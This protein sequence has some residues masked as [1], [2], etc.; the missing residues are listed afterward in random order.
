MIVRP[1]IEQASIYQRMAADPRA[2]RLASANAGSGKTKVLVERVS[3]LLLDGADPDK[4]L[5]LTYTKAAASEMQTRLFDTLGGWSVMDEDKLNAALDKLLGETQVRDQD[6]LGKARQL[7][8]KALETPDGLKVQTI[9]AFCERILSRFPLEAG[10]LPGFEPMDDANGSALRSEIEEQIYKEAR[11]LPE[12]PL[13]K[14][15][16]RLAGLKADQSLE[17][18]F[19]WIA[20]NGEAIGTW[21]ENGGTDG[22]AVFLGLEIGQSVDFYYAN[23]WN[24]IV[25]EKIKPA[26]QSLISSSNGNDS[27][28]G[29]AIL[30]ALT[31]DDV[32]AAF[33]NYSAIFLTQAGTLRKSVVTLQAPPAAQD[34]FGNSRMDPTPEALRVVSALEKITAARCLELTD[35]VYEIAKVYTARYERSKRER[36]WLDFNDQILLVR[37]LLVRADVA[38]WVK[39]KLD[40]GIGHILIDEAQDTAPEQWDIID[41]LKAGFSRPDPDW[42]RE[43]VKTFFAVGDEKQS[44]YSFQGARP[45]KFIEKIRSYVDEDAATSIRM[46]MSFRSSPDVLRVVDA[47]FNDQLGMQRMF[48]AEHVDVASELVSHTAFRQDRGFVEFW[49]LAPKPEEIEAETAWDTRPVDAPSQASPRER[50]AKEIATQ[51]KT[52]LD[53][54]EPVYDRALQA[55]RPMSAGDILILVRSRNAFF[56]AVIRNMKMLGVPVAGADRLVL[57][58]SVA[59]KDMLALTRFVLLPSD[60]LSLAEV[61]K[62]PLFD[63]TEDELFETAKRRGD[64]TLWQSLREQNFGKA[65]DAVEALDVIRKDARLF[66]PYEFYAKVLDSRTSD[67]Q[68]RLKRLFG[69]LGIEAKDAIEAFLARALAH[70]R[71][72]APSLQHFL[73]SFSSDNQDIKREMDAGGSEVRVMT[74][75][76]AKGLEAPVVFLPDTTQN[77]TSRGANGLVAVE[78]GFAY[79]PSKEDTPAPLIPMR[80]MLGARAGEEYMRLLYVAMTRAES[81]L[82]VCGYHSG[83]RNS[84][85]F[86]Q[87]SWYQE[88]RD[89]MIGL[90]ADEL[91]TPLGTGLAYGGPP[92][93]PQSAQAAGQPA[94]S[95]IPSW[96]ANFAREEHPGTRRVTPSY[97][98]AAQPSNGAPVRSPIS[99]SSDRFLRGNITHK[100]LEILPD[101]AREKRDAAARNYLERQKRLSPEL[102]QEIYDEVFA[103]LECPDYAAIFGPGSQAE[104]SLAGRGG[105]LP[106]NIYLNAQI[107]RLAVT[108]DQVFI[109]DYKS[110]RPPPQTQE[111]VPDIYWGQMAAYRELAREIYPDREVVC[112]LL[113]TDGPQMMILDGNRLD[114]ALTLIAALPT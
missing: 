73:Q 89:A 32:V 17:S 38:D 107:D 51:I 40:G 110:N 64:K 6:T 41:A 70:Q 65:M 104:V 16:E 102:A 60:D 109:V 56:D 88:V 14:A 47:V 55:T 36:R 37:N 82:I 83:H 28:K 103:V 7:F 61:L 19:K 85:G 100:L 2:T 76:G 1:D 27:A 44:I 63:F 69:R 71:Q 74:V 67:G 84:D 87:G 52:W 86:A 97:L 25:K 106:K 93:P 81:R 48:D 30:D 77:P 62:S 12:E 33:T 31:Q 111:H 105:G 22:L 78:G 113:W 39:Y 10:I 108:D 91:E 114:H 35:A 15:I 45:E 49:P 79:V 57:K 80:D 50:L 58:D 54:G 4:I 99:A 23:A 112:G 34:F 96:A 3:R 24:D 18:I 95:A 66:P 98:L 90:K 8:A 94:V 75:H 26:A 29:A 5:C 21:Q 13:A 59:V 11:R 43:Q 46:L 42:P 68:S 101:L 72:G 9:H 92:K 20:G 53:S